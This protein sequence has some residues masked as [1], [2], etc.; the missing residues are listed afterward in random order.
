MKRKFAGV[1]AA[2]LILVLGST[3]VYAAS[4]PTGDT[5]L[6]EQLQKLA[7]N[8]TNPKFLTYS[9]AW[10]E[11]KHPAVTVEDWNQVKKKADTVGEGSNILAMADLTPVTNTVTS[12][13]YAKG[14]RV[15]LKV[16]GVKS[17]DNVCILHKLSED[18]WEILKPYEVEDGCVRVMMYSLS[19]VA[20]VLYGEGVTITPD[21]PGS[22][23]DDPSGNGGTNQDGTSSSGGQSNSQTGSQNQSGSQ[24]QNG[25]QANTQDQNGSQTS[26]QDQNSAQ[27]NPQNQANSQNQNNPQNQTNNQTQSNNNNQNSNQTNDNN[28]SNSQVNN[29]N[30][31]VNVN[32]NVTVNYPSRDQY[33]DGY[34]KGFW[35]GYLAAVKKNNTTS[36][37]TNTTNKVVKSPK[38]GAALPAL[39]FVLLSAA[40]L[41]V[42]GKKARKS[43]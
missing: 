17:G 12:E 28:Q 31:P 37:K 32:Q 1:L 3:S 13:T 11:L 8:F 38:T 5:F 16:A 19:P 18:G 23:T 20:V 22:S 27:N 40:G 6:E 41:G 21:N 43:K 2:L 29:Q 25:S 33:D 14:I 4:S 35:A 39:P 7:D 36:G 9:S 30:N 15:V 26:T 34:G 42:C 10:L 24:D